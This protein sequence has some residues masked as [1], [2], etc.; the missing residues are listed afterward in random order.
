MIHNF[1]SSHPIWPGYE[2]YF[3]LSRYRREDILVRVSPQRAHRDTNVIP[4]NADQSKRVSYINESLSSAVILP[5]AGHQ[6]AVHPL[7]HIMAHLTVN[8]TENVPSPSSTF[9]TYEPSGLCVESRL[10]IGNSTL[11]KGICSD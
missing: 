2:S 9:K 1:P 8:S 3:T 7:R 4:K 11:N 6:H 10:A 5:A